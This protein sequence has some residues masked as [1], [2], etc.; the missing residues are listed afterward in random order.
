[1]QHKVGHSPNINQNACL[2]RWGVHGHATVPVP[3]A[4]RVCGAGVGQGCWI[5]LGLLAM[6]GVAG[7]TGTL[8]DMQCTCSGGS[9]DT[10]ECDLVVLAY[11]FASGM[12]WPVGGEAS[13]PSH[14]SVTG[15]RA[16]E[17]ETTH[18]YA[19]MTPSCRTK[20]LDCGSGSWG[21]SF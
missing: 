11:K 1:M 4:V 5:R 17:E 14:K 19:G 3:P 2:E 10:C 18:V 20:W 21:S 12:G 8:L 15:R 6:E 7:Q 9:C 16:A 13:S